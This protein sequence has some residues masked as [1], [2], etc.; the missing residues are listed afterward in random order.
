MTLGGEPTSF[1]FF[2][3]SFS[4]KIGE[5]MPKFY[6]MKGR[7]IPTYEKL[8][9]FS[10]SSSSGA[11]SSLFLAIFRLAFSASKPLSRPTRTMKTDSCIDYYRY[12]HNMLR[13]RTPSDRHRVLNVITKLIVRIRVRDGVR[14]R[15]IQ[16]V[17]DTF[18]KHP[19]Q[20]C[21]CVFVQ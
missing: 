5:A 16:P 19:L 6:K 18:S 10:A 11:A 15:H 14:W 2:S 12:V 8:S 4:V 21:E 20:L 3:S 13:R 7:P 1:F 17:H 9:T